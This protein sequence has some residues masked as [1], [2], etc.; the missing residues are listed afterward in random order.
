MPTKKKVDR[1]FPIAEGASR[2]VARSQGEEQSADEGVQEVGQQ[3]EQELEA[4]V[5][6]F[7]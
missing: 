1:E 6:A 3:P 7:L 2:Q 5:S 4:P